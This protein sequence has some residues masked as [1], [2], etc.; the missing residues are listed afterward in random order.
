[1]ILRIDNERINYTDSLNIFAEKIFG[2]YHQFV[3]NKS[4][5]I[6]QLNEVKS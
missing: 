2:L 5:K 3:V 1:M 6:A 4:V